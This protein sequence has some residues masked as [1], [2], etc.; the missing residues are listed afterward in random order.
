MLIF[1]GAGSGKTRTLTHRL[2]YMV[3]ECGIPPEQ[4]LAVTFT[5]KAANEM[6]E[7]IRLLIGDQAERVWAGTFHWFCARLL[8]AAGKAIGI[9]P[10]FTIYDE[11]DSLT[12]VKHALSALN[13]SQD[14]VKPPAV[15]NEISQ[16]KNRL[17]TVSE[18]RAAKDDPLGQAARQVYR[19]YQEELR[20]AGALDFDDLLMLA[21]QLLEKHPSVRKKYQERF[22]YLLVDEYQ[23]INYA[24]FRLLQLLAGERANLCVVG[25]DDQSIYGWRGADVSLILSFQRHF[26]EARIFHLERNYRSTQKILQA[27]NAIIARNPERAPKELWTENEPGEEVVLYTAVNEEE[28]AEW[29]VDTIRRL[30][31]AGEA[32][33]G[34]FA[35]LYRIN[36]MSRIFEEA[37]MAYNLPYEVIGGMRFFDRAEV[38][39]LVAYL[40]VLHNPDNS[41]A[42]RRIINVPTRGIGEGALAVLDRLALRQGTSLWGAL[43]LA[44]QDEDLPA[45]TRNAFRGFVD[46][47]Q[48]LRESLPEMSL[49]QL[50]REVIRRSGYLSRLRESA[51]ADDARRAENVEE[52]VNVAARFAARR[53]EA[54]ELADF[55]EYLALSSD[56]DQ[57]EALGEKVALLTLHS[58]KGLEFP[59][60]F[61]VGLEE[62]ILPHHRSLAGEEEDEAE[63]AEERRLLYVGMTRAQ[64]RLWLSHAAS[65]MQFGEPRQNAPSRFLADLP[66]EGVRRLGRTEGLVRR[67]GHRL[68]AFSEQPEM[69]MSGKPLDL[70]AILSRVRREATRG[71][72]AVAEAP[73]P[74]LQ[75]RSGGEKAAE[76]TPAEA[77]RFALGDK[78]VHPKFGQGM[79]VSLVEDRGSVIATVAF[80]GGGVKR[81]DLSLAR[82][83]KA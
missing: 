43:L 15:L 28:E 40:Q 72:Q 80:P 12:V 57:A 21:V 65:R 41:I 81:L 47:I 58:A 74:S 82:L 53:R 19:L 46:L 59:N 26:P 39:D 75:A 33:W 32:T 8:R 61:I 37:L 35:V 50:A 18:Y 60:V 24:Q 25:D 3:K 14:L 70:T 13:L 6:K 36:A 20:K 45:R 44:V 63:I 76:A 34:D 9:P 27:A 1:A 69:A 73:A 51:K 30:V 67:G 22:R 64:R 11:T 79:I 55:L 83:R 49:A 2:A 4:I 52:F 66:K 62:N 56:I 68:P 23:D 78:V 77:A 5:N 48:G 31:A 29:V 42:L 54:G 38:K 16:A 17:L 7:R 71:P 10:N